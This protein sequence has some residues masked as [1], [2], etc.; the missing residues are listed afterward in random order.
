MSL[1]APTGNTATT[2][3]TN[4]TNTTTTTN[5]AEGAAEEPVPTR[6]GSS[7]AA[8]D[9]RQPPRSDAPGSGGGS[10]W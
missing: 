1:M 5:P 6:A 7:S 8:A 4:T 3:T 2:A 9:P 10:G